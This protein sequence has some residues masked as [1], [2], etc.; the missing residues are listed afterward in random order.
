L[1]D[2][3]EKEFAGHALALHES[4]YLILGFT[5]SDFPASD[6]KRLFPGR[7][8]LF[9]K[10]VHADRIV[11]AS[12]WRAGTEADGI[13][14]DRPGVVAVIQTADCLPLFFFDDAR[15]CGGVIHVGWRGLRSGIEERLAAMLGADLGSFSF[16]LGPAIEKKCYEVGEEL[17]RLFAEKKYAA[18]IF[19]ANGRGKCSMDLK[20]GLKLSLAALG[21][22]AERIQDC[23]LCTYCSRGRFP[24]YRRDGKTG[25]RIFN[26]LLLKNGHPADK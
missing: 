20:A 11:A 17:P 2:L 21:V 25:K 26:F 5:G 6:L 16:F 8:L 13:F 4:E 12:D 9:L 19:S 23:G 24:S 15:R 22:A 18:A 14:L 10:Q 7:P 3:A 1:I